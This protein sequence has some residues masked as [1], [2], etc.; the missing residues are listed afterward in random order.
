[1]YSVDSLWIKF[2]INTVSRLSTRKTV[3]N[4][5]WIT[6]LRLCGNVRVIHIFDKHMR[7]RAYAFALMCAATCKISAYVRPA[8]FFAVCFA[9]IKSKERIY[10]PS[11]LF[12]CGFVIMTVR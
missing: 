11:L 10:Y 1:M 8:P 4:F 9:R 2:L 5:L 12:C 6:L 7:R 3:D